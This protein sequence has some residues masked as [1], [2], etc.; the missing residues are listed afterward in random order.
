MSK[1]RLG[2]PIGPRLEDAKVES[3]REYLR[4]LLVLGDPKE[5]LMKQLSLD[6][7]DFRD[8]KFLPVMGAIRSFG[9]RRRMGGDVTSREKLGLDL[10][11][12]MS[13]L[14]AVLENDGKLLGAVSLSKNEEGKLNAKAVRG[15]WRI[16]P[17]RNRTR[18]NASRKRWPRRRR[19]GKRVFVQET[20]TWCGPCRMLSRYV[21]N[22]KEIFDANFVWL[23]VDRVRD[24]HGSEVMTRYRRKIGGFRGL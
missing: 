19:K 10:G 11:S 15:R 2:K 6:L 8:R 5:E 9:Y 23:K 22:N 7:D 16:M 21:V 1:F 4:I 20:G 14:V 18:N 13:P 17:C 24:L 12:T 3:E